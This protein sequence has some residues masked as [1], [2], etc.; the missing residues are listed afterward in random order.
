MAAANPGRPKMP[1]P[2]M[3]LTAEAA[4]PPTPMTRSSRGAPCLT[5]VK[6]SPWAM[7]PGCSARTRPFARNGRQHEPE[8]CRYH[9][10]RDE[11]PQREGGTR[12]GMPAGQGEAQDDGATEG[13]K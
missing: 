4:R 6:R 11:R 12:L 13:A 8:E 2:T 1:D 5:S 7:C 3:Q 9:Q 10:R